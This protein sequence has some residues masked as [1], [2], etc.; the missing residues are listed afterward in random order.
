MEQTLQEEHVT[1]STSG[2]MWGMQRSAAGSRVWVRDA[3][4]GRFADP[5]IQQPVRWLRSF[6]AN[7]LYGDPGV[8]NMLTGVQ[9]HADQDLEMCALRQPFSDAGDFY[10]K[11]PQHA[12]QCCAVWF[13]PGH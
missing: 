3:C 10:G 11:S 6:R 2:N 1:I 12:E 9:L 13:A 7:L 8:L 4:F 5:Q